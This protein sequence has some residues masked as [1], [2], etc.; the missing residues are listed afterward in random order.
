MNILKAPSRWPLY[1]GIAGL[2][3]VLVSLWYTNNL[4]TQLSE[5]EQRQ[6]SLTEQAYERLADLSDLDADF[7][8]EN[9]ILSAVE[10]QAAIIVDANTNE[11][12]DSRLM[13]GLDTAAMYR[14][15]ASWIDEGRKPI[16]IF[17]QIN[18]FG[19]SQL[20][21]QL[22]FF[23]VIL[24]FLI[25]TFVVMGYIGL[26]QTRK[27]EQNRVWVGM[28]KETAHQLGTPISAI[29]G[30]VEHLKL[31][32]GDSPDLME[33]SDE[34]RKDVDRLSMVAN[35]FSKIGA[36]PELKPTNIFLK[37]DDCKAYMSARAPRKVKFSFPPADGGNLQVAIN[38]ILFD[39]VI[40][41][42]LR[43]ALDAMD[44]KGEISAHIS[45]TG[46]RVFID[47]TD[48]GKGIEAKNIR[49][50]FNPGF[51]TK[52]R[53]WGLGLSLVKR[54]VEEY[55]QGRIQVSRSEPGVGTTFTISLPKV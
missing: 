39:W 47:I 30:W 49:R 11:I 29:V 1:L 20:L 16:K 15:I 6:L 24:F 23:P 44:G 33:V 42:L 4:A 48:T 14:Q 27:A 3:I 41:N 32:Y 8:L 12:I 35:R 26:N 28:A 45:E 7:T 53:G 5:I 34:L 10:T 55:H 46:G 17:D 52:Q 2:A 40:E 25:A 21:R 22:R 50:V 31:M 38:P 13:E 37:L 51:T 9:D 19:E 18:Y 36:E 54:I 43:N